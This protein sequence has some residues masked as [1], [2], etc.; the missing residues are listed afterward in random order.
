MVTGRKEA[1][2]A[3]TKSAFFLSAAI[4][5]SFLFAIVVKKEG[6]I[7]WCDS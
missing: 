2:E 7:A 1:I 6:L 4:S 3:A 5:L